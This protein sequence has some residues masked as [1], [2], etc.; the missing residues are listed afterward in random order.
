MPSEDTGYIEIYNI[1]GSKVATILIGA[2]S[3]GESTLNIPIHN[4]ANG[5]YILVLQSNGE[6]VSKKFVIRK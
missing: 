4:L 5:I 3:K 6:S 2:I 1:S